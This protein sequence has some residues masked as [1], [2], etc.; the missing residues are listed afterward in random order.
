MCKHKFVN[1]TNK[2]KSDKREKE[3]DTAREGKK[4][5]EGEIAASEQG[6]CTILLFY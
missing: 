4:L 3:I 2:R 6:A 1:A 5:I